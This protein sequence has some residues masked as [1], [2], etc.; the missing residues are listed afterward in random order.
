MEE[1]II[2]VQIGVDMLVKKVENLYP[3]ADQ[4]EK[5]A[6][7][8]VHYFPCLAVSLCRVSSHCHFYNKKSNSYIETRLKTLRGN[9]TP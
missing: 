4:K 9:L 6:I 1:R 2:I 5:L 7:S 3:T 8:I